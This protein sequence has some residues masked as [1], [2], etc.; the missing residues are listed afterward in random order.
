M[1]GERESPFP[2]YYYCGNTGEFK[3]D[4]DECSGNE[5]RGEFDFLDHA[6]AT[7][8]GTYL[9]GVNEGLEPL[10]DYQPG[11]FHP[12]HLGDTLG[13][14]QRYRVI[15]KLGHG[16]FGTVWLC[17]DTQDSGYVAVKVM[18]EE[19]KQH[20][21]Q[22]L[23]IKNLD[24]SVPGADNIAIP[25]DSFSMDGP[26]GSHQCIVLPV[27][28]PCVSPNLWLQLEKDPGPI[29]RKMS[30]QAVL[31]MKWLHT[32]GFCHGDFRPSNIL[33]KLNDLNHLSE[34]QLLSL[35]GHPEK[36]YVRTESGED[37]PA[38]SPQYLILPADISR[39]GSKYLSEEICIIDF[40]EVFPILS[41]P[42][43]LGIPENYLP[44]E[45]L[46]EQENAIGPACDI[47]ALEC[48]LFE[49]RQQVPLFYMIYDIDELLAEMIRLFGKPLPAW[50]DKWEAR[51]DFFDDQGK[52]L[53][54]RAD[55]QELS[56]EVVLNNLVEI[57]APEMKK[58]I[59]SKKEQGLMADLLHKILAYDPEQ[60]LSVDGVLNHEWFKME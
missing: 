24:R 31:A 51:E 43:D 55:T 26:N 40:G 27:L 60:R 21:V 15:H 14:S 52:W 37:L 42:E 39:L 7:S 8:H 25:L 57:V 9:D 50:W 16:G 19:A 32:N 53:R 58:L 56:L 13:P 6:P 4:F 36:A 17:R 46:L 5:P 49:I 18:V 41:P 33:V 12:V 29:L 23:L 48:T 28:G 47:W 59:T 1:S 35:L 3:I 11:G 10:E 54:G 45:V 44:P 20:D 38:S 22:D 34:E 30:Y 2:E